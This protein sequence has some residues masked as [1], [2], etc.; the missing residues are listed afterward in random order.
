MRKKDKHIAQPSKPGRFQTFQEM[1]SSPILF[2]STKSLAQRQDELNEAFTQ[3]GATY[4][5]SSGRRSKKLN[6]KTKK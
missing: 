3:L 4:T 2:P 5:E 1:K 6:K